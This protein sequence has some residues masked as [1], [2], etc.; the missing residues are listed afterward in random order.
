[1][2][3]NTACRVNYHRDI[4]NR[5]LCV[6]TNKIDEKI[7]LEMFRERK[8]LIVRTFKEH[9]THSHFFIDIDYWNEV[10]LQNDKLSN[11]YPKIIKDAK[12]W[13]ERLDNLRGS[14]VKIPLIKELKK[15]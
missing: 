4:K 14:V 8:R 12:G 15:R 11:I 2:F 3:H 13:K 1:M 10:T 7:V 9:P 5:I 6:T